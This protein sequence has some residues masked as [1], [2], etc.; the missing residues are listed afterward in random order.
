MVFEI[1]SENRCQRTNDVGE[2]MCALGHRFLV[3]VLPFTVRSTVEPA[4]VITGYSVRIGDVS[5][6]LE[7]R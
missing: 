3:G 1:R 5:N 6:R 7:S 4:G 2:I